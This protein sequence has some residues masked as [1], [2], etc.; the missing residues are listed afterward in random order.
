M[1]LTWMN[2]S[3]IGSICQQVRSVQRLD[4]IDLQNSAADRAKCSLFTDPSVYTLLA[5]TSLVCCTTVA[6]NVGR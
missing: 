4:V 3:S 1:V 6:A 5:R 2:V